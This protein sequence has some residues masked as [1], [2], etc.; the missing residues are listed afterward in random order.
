MKRCSRCILPE[1]FPGIK[2]DADGICNYCLL[3]RKI[4]AKGEDALEGLLSTYRTLAKDKKYDCM[5]CWSGGRD[6]SYALYQLVKKHKLRVLA[7]TLDGGLITEFGYRNMER[8]KTILGIDH[9]IIVLDQKKVLRHV[10]KNIKAWL[11]KPSLLMIPIFMSADKTFGF[12]LTKIGKEY[13]VP[14]LVMG[15]NTGVESTSFKAAYAGVYEEPNQIKLTQSL[16]LLLAYLLEYITNPRY[17]NGSLKYIIPGWFDFFFFQTHNK[18]FIHYFEYIKWNEDEIL[19]TIRD[20]LDW[21]TPPD[22]SQTWRT[23]DATSPWYN[24]L[25]YS[26]RGFTENDELLSNMIREGMIGREEALARVEQENQPRYEEIQ[27]YLKKVGVEI[28]V[29]GLERKLAEYR[30]VK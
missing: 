17:I 2:V 1:T 26:M 6:S 29:H 25:Y 18:N 14:L 24:F 15:G 19:T 8:A 12:K 13:D 20:E 16:R 22:T 11:K 9:Q 27:K 28:D 30:S 23:D 21:E 3:Y 4:E 5:V 7:L 10:G